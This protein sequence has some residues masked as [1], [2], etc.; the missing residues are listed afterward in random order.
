MKK[1]LKFLSVVSFVF[2]AF[3]ANG[4][5]DY[6]A[7]QIGFTGG[8]KTITDPSTGNQTIVSF[9]GGIVAPSN[10]HVAVVPGEIMVFSGFPHNVLYFK[11]VFA[12]DIFVSKG[13]FGEY[14]QLN[15]EI[16]SAADQIKRFKIY[17]KVLGSPDDSTLVASVSGDQYAWKDE[18]VEK[19]ILYDYTLYAEGI[20]EKLR[21]PYINIMKGVGFALPTGT[22]SGRVTYTGGTAVEGVV[23]LAETEGNLG[24]RSLYLNGTNASLVVPHTPL[25]KE[26]EIR[27][28]FTLQMWCKSEGTGNGTLFSKGGQYNLSYQPG[29]LTFTVKGA[30]VTLNFTQPVDTFFHVTAVYNQAAGK[31]A[32]Y[33]HIADNRVD[34]AKADATV[35]PVEALDNITFGRNAAGNFFHGNIDE[36][37]LWNKPLDFNAIRNN[38]SRYIAGTEQGLIGYWRMNEGLSSQFYDFSRKGF[39]YYENHGFIRGGQWSTVT[40]L[41]SQ[42]A[43]RGV[44]D[45]EGNYTITGFPYLTEGSLYKFTPTYQTHTFD[46]VQQIRLIADG[47]TVINGL[48]FTDVSSFKVTGTVRYRNT[49]FP[50]EGVSV[51]IDG[52][53]ATNKESQV[54][55]TDNLGRFEVD[56]PIGKHS[57]RVS[58][59]LHGFENEGR[60]PIPSSGEVYDFQQP[61]SGLEFIDTTLVKVAGRV[62][63]G[64]VEEVKALGFGRSKNN[65]GNAK[66][67][68]TTEKGYDLTLADSTV[69]Y[70]EEHITSGASFTTKFATLSPDPATGEYVAYLIPEKFKVTGVS[71]GNYTYPESAQVTINLKEYFTQNE[72]IQDTLMASVKGTNLPDYPP[73]NPAKYDTLVY[74]VKGDTTFTLGV[75]S[76]FYEKKQ[77]FIY[78]ITPTIVVTNRTGGQMFGDQEFIYDNKVLN[79][80]DTIPLIKDGAYTFGYPVFNDRKNYTMVVRL[81]EEYTNSSTNATD[82]V[83][84]IDGKLEIV[85]NL[86]IET[87]KQTLQ[88]DGKGRALYNFAG[89]A[90]EI[91]KDGLNP[92]RSFTKTINIVAFS[93]SEGAIKTIWRENDPFRGFLFGGV[94]VGNDFVTSGPTE[95]VT[96]LRDP[97]GSGSSTSLE[98]GQSTAT[99]VSYGK[100]E[101]LSESMELTL[102]F[103]MTTKSWVGVGG[104]IITETE[105]GNDM[106]IGLE[107]EQVWTDDFERTVTTTTTKS[108]ATSAD[109]GYVGDAADV[110]VGYATNIV[111]GKSVILEIIPTTQCNTCL[112]TDYNGFTIG[113]KS[114]LRINPEVASTFMHSQTHIKD[115]LIPNLQ[116]LRNSF[117]VY[118]T[119]TVP[120][121][122][123]DQPGDAGCTKAAVY[124]SKVPLGD[125]GFGLSNDDAYWGENAVKTPGNGPSYKIVTGKGCETFYTKDTVEYFNHQIAE[126]E[127]WLEENERQ[128]VKSSKEVENISFDAGVS[129]TKSVITDSAETKSHNF[130]WNIN[131]S[132]GTDL[133]F[134]FLGFGQ[135][136]TL[137][138]TYGAGGSK[139]GSKEE[140]FSTTYSY[141]LEE[142]ES[143]DYYSVNIRK[144]DDGFGPVFKVNGGVT[145]CP[146]EGETHTEYYTENGK[147]VVLNPATVPVD[148]PAIEVEQAIVA[149]VASNRAAEFKLI[150]KNNSGNEEDRW[151]TLTVDDQTNPYG[152]VIEIDGAPIANG[153]DFLVRS[154]TM[155][156]KTLKVRRGQADVMDYENIRIILGSQCEPDVLFDDVEISA[157][158]VPGC[159]D[160]SMEL[161]KNNW[162]VN[163]NTMPE[164]TLVV[165]LN[166]YNLKHSDFK[167]IAFQYKPSGSSQWTTDMIFYN[168]EFVSEEEFEK[169]SDPKKWIS[170][171]S[172]VY[173]WDMHSLPDRNYDIRAKT[174][175]ELGPGMS[176]ETPTDIITGIK[177]VKKPLLFGAPQP[178]DGVLS[179]GEEISIQFDEPI[180][181][182]LLTPF[183]FS[184]QGVLNGYE[185]NHNTSVDFDGVN[186]FVKIG[187]GL[188]VADKSFTVEFWAKRDGSG[189]EEVLFSK[190]NS[191][192]D[193][194]EI[195]FDASDKLSVTIGAQVITSSVSVTG[196]DWNHFAVIYRHADK[197]LEAYKNDQFI[198]ENISVTSA[199][200]AEG[201]IVLGKSGLKDDGYFNGN[202]HELRVWTKALQLGDVYAKM[203]KSLSGSEIGLAGYW[204]FDEGNGTRARD[205]ARYRHAVVNA[206][207]SVLPESKAVA[208]D[209]IDDYLGITTGNTVVVSDEMD[210]TIELWFRGAEGQQNVTLFSSGKGDG[211]DAFNKGSLNIGFNAAG[212]LQVTGNGQVLIAGNDKNFLD[213]NW[214]HLAFSLTRRGNCNLFADGEL[215]KSQT[216]GGFGSLSGVKMWLGARGY[217]TGSLTTVYDQFFKG[218]IDEFRIWKTA[219]KQLEIELTKDSKLSGEEL[220]LIA[221]YPFEK[222][223]TESG[224]KKSITSLDDQ[225]KNPYGPNGGTGTFA[226]AVFADEAPNIKDAR[227]VTKVDFEWVVNNDKIIIKTAPGMAPV[228]EKSIL[229]ITVEGVEDKFENRLASPVSWTAFVDRNQLK[230][231]EE[232]LDFEKKLNEPLSFKAEIIN[233]GGVQENFTINNIPAWLKVSAKTGTIAPKSSMEVTFTVHEGLNTGV[234]QEDL[235]LEGNFG[236]GEKLIVGVR[237]F[238]PVPDDWKVNPDNFQYSMNIIGQISYNGKIS[239]NESDY[240][241]VFKGDSCIGLAELQYVETLDNYQAYLTVYSNVVSETG[242]TYKIWNAGEGHV[243]TDITPYFNFAANEVHGTPS[244][245][246]VFDASQGIIEATVTLPAGWKWVSLNLKSDDLKIVNNI[247]KDLDAAEGDKIKGKTFYD[248]FDT[249]KGWIGTLTGNGGIRNEEMYK[250]FVNEPGTFRYKGKYLN[251]AET[252]VTVVSGWNWIGYVPK[253]NMGINEALAGL[254][255]TSGDLV[256]SQHRFAVYDD[257]LGWV[258]N[259]TVMKPGEGYMLKSAVNTEFTYPE[260]TLLAERRAEDEEFVTTNVWSFDP[261]RFSDNMSVI[262]EVTLPAGVTFSEEDLVGAFAGEECRGIARP[263]YNPVSGKYTFFV[264]IFGTG[265]AEEVSFRY[266][267]AV[268]SRESFAVETTSLNANTLRGAFENPFELTFG[269]TSLRLAVSPNPFSDETVISVNAE[270]DGTVVVEVTDMLGKGINTIADKSVRKGIHTFKWNGND[271]N[272]LP[273]DQGV[274]LIQV[275]VNEVVLTQKLVKY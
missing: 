228:I 77:N 186:D 13:Y 66:I 234:Y 107:S 111:Y 35:Q 180:E 20:S 125:E 147:P 171:A 63:G 182:S 272:G 106:V 121:P 213:N 131:P 61:L 8:Q 159:S 103:G 43:F 90:P 196:N 100:T 168:P 62:A 158:F 265:K 57:L 41:K 164:D 87:G 208:F 68:L 238:T 163:S 11:R 32:L 267:S 50:V 149:D 167:H 166:N 58:R 96:I 29:Q 207:W 80:K 102:K 67:Y 271:R 28:G 124:V 246:V 216:S 151:Y 33:T 95:I 273:A 47:N 117:L 6:T 132:L 97:P 240:I 189:S 143:S 275:K 261:Y 34:S 203:N 188:N 4:Q 191:P 251:P 241:A 75:D 206:G 116:S 217:K 27:N 99:T 36:V 264:T 3:F 92:G 73:F 21:M 172:L 218:E 221:Y 248:E 202:L 42:L 260:A 25:D 232:K 199:F 93:G 16:S 138:M 49:K 266:Y 222:Y 255:S 78:R 249:Q 257:N 231:S 46:P 183:N 108:W 89:G 114:G 145:S 150:L 10:N 209:G 176:V 175:C 259:L 274:Y 144:A 2:Y 141:T 181:A 23:V 227:P 173:P 224:I 48:N 136:L 44:T 123:V 215:I 243:Y 242:L 225:W 9:S 115:V 195:G 137:S 110:F 194:V 270:Q 204:P 219:R 230:W 39:T 7:T 94:P 214:H 162:V 190:G 148:A 156:Q 112:D 134:E 154:G 153:R 51:L 155:L 82:Q 104:G 109:P 98:S 146:Y 185:L 198:L 86:A 269:E 30:S 200:K 237:N 45:S 177:D 74:K 17:R 22:A 250:I 40:P 223:I 178:A 79:R 152:A 165:K 1:L 212:S 236:Y 179:A 254:E 247:L 139:G 245:P 220:G 193:L 85:N 56:V 263:V 5:S 187:E 120:Q 24:G 18:Y 262:A 233:H 258:G 210:F 81:Y 184:V 54:I 130:E 252:P 19:G 84:V 126:W 128:K 113:I 239:D 201:Q 60:F 52:K 142:S 91:N 76:F 133:G 53:P 170:G 169:V 83:P 55:M 26:L 256:K 157:Y 226:G 65:L 140:T 235:Y 192:S 174:V 38:Y 59:H 197:K 122:D 229:E 268:S 205:K 118:T 37:R 119:E 70:T 12:K 253:N 160:I 135:D 15:W 31:I 101:S 244:A 69:N 71:A 72:T 129:Y 64:P 88:L 127:F 105:F 211:T 161:P 14:V